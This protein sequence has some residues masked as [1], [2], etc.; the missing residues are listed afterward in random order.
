MEPDDWYILVLI[1]VIVSVPLFYTVMDYL[2]NQYEKKYLNDI[3][4]YFG[5]FIVV[6][7]ISTIALKRLKRSF[8]E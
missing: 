2:I 6:F 5:V 4:I 3:E 7:V 1:D 8:N